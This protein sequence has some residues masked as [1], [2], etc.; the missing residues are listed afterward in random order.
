MSIKITLKT[1]NFPLKLKFQKKQK[2][3]AVTKAFLKVSKRERIKISNKRKQK[4]K[5]SNFGK[6]L[7]T[8]ERRFSQVAGILTRNVLKMSY[9]EI[10]S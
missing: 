2:V 4:H 10:F 5:N 6:K 8:K 9:S 1:T 3:V 7:V